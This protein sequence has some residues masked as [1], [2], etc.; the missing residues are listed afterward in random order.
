MACDAPTGYMVAEVGN[1]PTADEC[2]TDAPPFRSRVYNPHEYRLQRGIEEPKGGRSKPRTAGV[3]TG[4]KEG[5]VTVSR[6]ILTMVGASWGQSG[7]RPWDRPVTH[8]TQIPWDRQPYC[9][10]R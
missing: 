3:G 2:D 8:G 1:N 10:H 6:R 5:G 7:K 4:P 9:P